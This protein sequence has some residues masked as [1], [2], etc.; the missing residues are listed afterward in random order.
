MGLLGSNHQTREM[1]L[2]QGR[3]CGPASLESIFSFPLYSEPE[4]F[5]QF[6]LEL[7]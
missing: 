5:G 1:L 3:V 7:V 4:G 2:K 6:L